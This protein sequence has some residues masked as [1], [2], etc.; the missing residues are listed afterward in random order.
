MGTTEASIFLA[1]ELLVSCDFHTGLRDVTGSGG[2]Y[3]CRELW[4]RVGASTR[5]VQGRG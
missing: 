4:G 2:T 3:S 5:G 1:V